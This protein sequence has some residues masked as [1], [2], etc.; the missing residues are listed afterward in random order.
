MAS[1]KSV[2]IYGLK[3]SSAKEAVINFSSYSLIY[4]YGLAFEHT[5]MLD[6]YLLL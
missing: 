4:G 6:L 5:V 2:K 3:E 1:A